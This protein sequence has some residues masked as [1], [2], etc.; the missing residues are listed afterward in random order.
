MTKD[1]KR[2]L[3]AAVQESGMTAKEAL[4]RLDLPRSTFYRWRKKLREQGVEGLIDRSSA[5]SRVWNQLLPEEEARIVKT[6]LSHP[7]WSSREIAFHLTDHASFSVSESTVYRWFKRRGW[8]RLPETKTFPAGPE[9]RIKTKDPNEQWQTDATYL[10]IID[11]GWYYLIS[12]LDDFSRKILAWKLCAS[13]T[14]EDFSLVVE[15]AVE[16]TGLS[17]APQVMMPRLVSDR[18]P[19]LISSAFQEY[20]ET[21]HIHHIL[22]SPY[23][24]QT[25]G[26]I[27]RY[28]QTLKTPLRLIPWDMP[29]TIEKE[30]D[31]FNHFY[32][33][34]RYHEALGNVTPDD[35]YFGRRETILQRRKQQKQKTM[36][37]RK[38]FNRLRQE[39]LA[40]EA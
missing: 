22:A 33:S 28:H 39:S 16:A 14:A 32:N 37:K 13:M 4:Q 36:Q 26:K 9:Y 15:K 40:E 1:R 17:K 30:I 21:R 2:V 11:W 5:P 29:E 18:G 7:T 35:V 6:A 25:N 38:L 3:L 23:H 34:E 20:L 19:A 24:P 10:K 31:R 27:E 12:V 8:I